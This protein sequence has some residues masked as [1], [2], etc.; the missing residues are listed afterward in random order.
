MMAAPP[1]AAFA[2]SMIVFIFCQADRP[3]LRSLLF[4][5]FRY[6]LVARSYSVAFIAAF[7]EFMF[8]FVVIAIDVLCVKSSLSGGRFLR[9]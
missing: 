3:Q 1:L 9:S 7:R 5:L 6:S 4:H 2:E 8:L